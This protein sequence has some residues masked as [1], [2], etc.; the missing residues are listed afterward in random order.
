MSLSGERNVT[1]SCIKPVHHLFHS[2][3]LAVHEDDTLV[4]Q[5]FKI[6]ILNYLGEKFADLSTDT[7]LDI[8]SLV[9]PK[10]KTTYTT[11]EKLEEIK[12]RAIMEMVAD[13]MVPDQVAAE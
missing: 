8:S 11:I 2:S 10:L 12:Y 13:V 6:S 7:L 1:L 4:M 9:D 3:I 5:S